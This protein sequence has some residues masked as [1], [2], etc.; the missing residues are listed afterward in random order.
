[1][2]VNIKNK[3]LHPGFLSWIFLKDYLQQSFSL[4][5]TDL[6]A[7]HRKVPIL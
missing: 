5:K 4:T 6:K 2:R 7:F 3:F 1:M